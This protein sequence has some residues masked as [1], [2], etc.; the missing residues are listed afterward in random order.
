[1]LIV[2]GILFIQG[3]N[4]PTAPA[5]GE[6]GVAPPDGEA[7]EVAA[8]PTPIPDDTIGV[9]VSLQTLPRGHVITEDIL[10]IDR[11]PRDSVEGNVIT[12]TQ[13]AV[14]L[15]AR[16]DI[17]QGQTLTR[18]KLTRDIRD[19]GEQLIG[20]SS[21]IPPGFVAQAIPVRTLFDVNGAI[22]TVGYGVSEGDYVDIM[23][24]FYINEVDEEFQTFLPND[25]AFFVE[26][27]IESVEDPENEELADTFIYL[28]N[29]F[30]RFEELPT[31]DLAHIAPREASREYPVAMI[32]QNAKVIQVGQYV[33]PPPA[34]G[35]L[36]TP[37]PTPLPEGQPTP[38][39]VASGPTAT[40]LPPDVVTVALQPQQQLLIRYAIEVGGDIDLALRGINDG[41][42]YSVENVDLNF[43]LERFNIE[44]P[45]N[46]GYSVDWG[47]PQFSFEITPTALPVSPGGGSAPD[48]GPDGSGS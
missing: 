24:M 47:S 40:P 19:I 20:P 17:F 4:Q 16:T 37:T 31:G 18:D 7:G 34:S 29:P 32:I 8:Q 26:E 44:M 1:M 12:Q 22:S 46:Y 39:P 14:G 6:D 25:A 3:Q 10:A 33:P 15:F 21:L 35:Q 23:V 43:L 11:R 42:L 28:V 13:D 45:P 30:G 27:F 9:V 2:V 38:T 36:A 48:P 41:Q 5:E